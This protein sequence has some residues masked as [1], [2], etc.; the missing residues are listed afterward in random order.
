VGQIGTSGAVNI[1]QTSCVEQTEIDSGLPVLV[2]DGARFSDLQGFYEEVSNRLIP[3]ASWGRNLDAF[4]DILRGGFGTPDDGF[5][6]RWVNSALSRERLGWDATIGFVEQ[7]LAT[8]HP[9]NVPNVEADL[10]AARRHE[11]QTLFELIVD[12]IRRHGTGGREPDER[13]VLVLE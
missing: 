7:K 8:C 11:G 13:V 6:L 5:E 1:R 12:I 3:G 10:S 4:N 9:Q 2:L